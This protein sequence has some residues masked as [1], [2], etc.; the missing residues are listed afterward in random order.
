MKQA[1]LMRPLLLIT[2]DDG[3]YSPGLKAAAQAAA[4]LGDL[5]IVAPRFQ[6]TAMGRAL[7][8]GDTVGVIEKITL[9]IKGSVHDAYAVHG[10]PAL[11]VAYAITELTQR[12]PDLCISGI[13][14]GEN[15]GTSISVSGTIGAALEAASMSVPGVAVSVETDMSMHYADDYGEVNWET[16]AYF[17]RHFA[18][19]MLRFGAPSQTALL[20]VNVPA[21]ATPQTA[22]RF[23]RQSQQPYYVYVRPENRDHS[24]AY[25][26]P[27]KVEVDRE[28]LEPDSD[29]KA[30]VYDRVIS[31]TPLSLDF[32]AKTTLEHWG[33]VEA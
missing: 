16:A 32:T 14:Y 31:V 15:V 25:R 10:S 17:T 23:T 33:N 18:E 21:D 22:V 27:V 26:L 6:Q 2:N 1:L 24:K 9:E 5:L 29:V 30:F 19:K 20:N 13:N 3:I 4:D 7:P 8:K 11:A 28:T 12:K